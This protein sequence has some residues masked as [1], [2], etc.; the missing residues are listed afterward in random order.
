MSPLIRLAW[1][2][3]AATGVLSNPPVIADPGEA[4][5][6]TVNGV[7]L[8]SDQVF[9]LPGIALDVDV[10][11]LDEE[12]KAQI[13]IGL[14]NRQ[15]VLEQA[16]KDGFDRSA[17]VVKAVSGM[18]DTYIVKQYLAKVA[19]GTDLSEEA[20]MAYY[21]DNYLG[22]PEQYRIAHILLADED[23]ANAV[24]G[25]TRTGEE[26]SDLA[27]DRS[28]DHVS[29]EKGGDLGWFTSGD[30]LPAFYD[31]VSSLA[32]GTTA[33]KPVKTPFGWH[34]VRLDEK[35]EPAPVNLEQARQGILQE[36][37]QKEVNGY[38]ERLRDNATIEIR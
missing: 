12:K 3:A 13:T 31:V 18:A 1:Y 17:A 34:V 8:T 32:P 15:L 21:R 4:V 5:L 7:N 28:K 11:T 22:R 38:L 20:V 25:L 30:M 36:L 27:R 35:R 16:R 10:A 6:A 24:L 9:E 26:F 37:I 33:T 29:A 2:L 19:A 14:I 23:E